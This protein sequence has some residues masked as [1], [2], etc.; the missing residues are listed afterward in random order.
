LTVFD[1]VRNQVEP[2]LQHR[3]HVAPR[4]DADSSFATMPLYMPMAIMPTTIAS[5]TANPPATKQPFMIPIL[6]VVFFKSP[7]SPRPAAARATA[8][9]SAETSPAPASAESAAAPAPPAGPATA[10]AAADSPNARSKKRTPAENQQEQ[11]GRQADCP[12][13]RPVRNRFAA[14]D[15]S[16]RRRR[17]RSTLRIVAFLEAGHDELVLNASAFG[18]VE[19]APSR[20]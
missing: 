19:Q 5:K 12:L 15:L 13:G 14:H 9:E 17:R 4:L 7:A 8:A 1:Q 10:L 3:F 11:K 16:A 2:A 18:V 6:S 20:P